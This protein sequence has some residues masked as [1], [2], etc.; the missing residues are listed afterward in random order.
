MQCLLLYSADSCPSG[1]KTRNVDP[2]LVALIEEIDAK[3]ATID[4]IQADFVQRKEISLLKEPV[5]MKGVF[6]LKRPDGIKFDFDPEQ[7]LIL[8]ITREEMVSL[9]HEAKKASRITMKKRRSRLAQRLLSEKL[10]TLLK[11]FK[12]EQRHRRRVMA[13]RSCYSHPRNAS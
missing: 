2:K 6:T 8:I 3:S 7:D 5:E 10:K 9:S 13:I 4:T 1:D 12:I 11:Y